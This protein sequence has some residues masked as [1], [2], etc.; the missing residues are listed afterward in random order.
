MK[1]ILILLILF[2]NAAL[3]QNFNWIT[4]NKQ[5][6]KLYISEDGLYRINKSDFINS[7][8][9]TSSIDPRTVK[10][11]Y[12]GA[13]IPIYFF[14]E[15]NGIFD[16]S[17]YFDFYGKRNYGGTTVTYKAS[18]SATNTVD[19]V[20][21]EY[22]NLYSDTS[23]YWVD[24]G[25]T[26]GLRYSDYVNSSPLNYPDTYFLN[27]IQFE[28]DSI[29]S[30]GE[31][32]SNDDYRNFN[33]EKISGEGWFW[34]DMQRGNNVSGYFNLPLLSQ[35]PQTCYIKLFAYP[36]S[37]SDTIFN[38]HK[39]IIRVN[40]T[41]IDTLFAD[42]YQR[43]DTTVNFSSALLS[44][45]S[46]NQ[47]SVTYTGSGT[48]A[49]HMLFDFFSLK[50]PARFEFRDNLLSFASALADTSAR[51]FKVKG[52]VQSGGINIYDIK[53][54][55]RIPSVSSN[56]DTLIFTGK[57]N[58]QYE[59]AN[60]T[61]TKKPF[62][63]KQ[64][65]VPDFISGSNGT[66]YLLIYNKLLE[67]PAEM[68]RQHRSSPSYDNF[69]TYKAEIEDIY[70][71][72]NYGMEN[73]VA[74]RYFVKYAY[75]NWQT[76]K[77]SYL[78]L[79]GRGSLDP[80]G[81]MASY[82]NP[83]YYQNLIPVYGNPPSDGYYAN[84]NL[85]ASTYFNQISV[86]RIPALTI[87]EGVDIVNKTIQYES[88]RTT[89]DNW[90]KNF[91]FITGGQNIYEQQNFANQ[92]DDLISR[93]IQP[94]PTAG[95]PVR[96]YRSDSSGYIS[97]NYS[98]SIKNAINRG[99]LITNY[100][101][102]AA[103]KSWDNGIE[104]P[105]ILQNSDKLSLI[106][107]MTCFT[108]KN[109]E[110]DRSFGET[111]ITLQN[112]GA[113]GFVGTTGWS[114][115]GSGNTFNDYMLKSFSLDTMRRT[116]DI[117]RYA[118]I[119]LAQDSASYASKNTVNCYSLLGDPAAMLLIPK[120]SEFAIDQSNY[121]L[122]NQFPSVREPVTLSIRPRN[123]GIYADSVK[124][125]FQI[126]KNSKPDR[127]KDT[128]IYG[129]GF[130]DTVDYL[131]SLDSAGNYNMTVT[132]DP[133]NWNTKE[134]KNNNSI[135]FQLN[136]KNNSFVP[137][138]PV[139]NQLSS[140]DSV[141]FTGINPNVDY[142]SN[143][144]KL[145]LQVDTSRQFG[146]A[147]TY[148][149]NSPKGVVTSFKIK[150][151]NADSGRVFFWR[152]NSVVNG[153]SSGWSETRKI[154]FGLNSYSYGKVFQDSNV[155]VRKHLDGQFTSSELSNASS[156]G[157]VIRLSNYAGTVQA[158]SGT[159]ASYLTSFIRINNLQYLF[160]GD[161]YRG[162]NI[163]KVNRKTANVVDYRNFKINSAQSSDSVIGYLNTFDTSDIAVMVKAYNTSDGVTMS[164]TARAKIREFGS[165]LVDSIASFNWY[166]TWSFI[167]YKGAVNSDV[168]ES[169]VRYPGGGV[170]P[171]P[172]LSS[173]DFTFIFTKGY[174]YNLAGPVKR[175]GNLYWLKDT[176]NNTSC[177]LNIYGNKPDGTGMLLYSGITGSS[178]NLDT[179]A[180]LN[181]PSLR[182]E[183]N[184]SVDSLYGYYSPSVSDFRFNY[185]PPA[186]II[187]DNN[188]FVKT[189]SVLQEGDTLT[190]SVR[191]YNCGFASAD[192]FINKWSATSPSGI[193]T[194]K[195]DTVYRSLKIDSFITVQERLPTAGLRN[196]N[197]RYD[198]VTFYF[199][200][201][202]INQNEFFLYNNV[203]A[204]KSVLTGDTLKPEMDIT[205]D[206]IRAV[207]GEYIS[208]KPR[209]VLKF[210][211][212][213][214]IFIKDTS[215]IRV[216]LDG[217]YI[218]YYL[219]GVK[220]PLIDLVFPAGKYL[221]ATLYFN[222]ALSVGE[223]RFDFASSDANG[224]YSDTVTHYMIVNPDLSIADLKN[225]P[226]PMKNETLFLINLSGSYPPSS[227]KI[228]IFTVAGRV[229]KT[230][231]A[232][233]GIGYNQVFW[234]GRD[235]DGDY[236]AN[237]VY[238]YKLIIEGNSR[239][240]TALQK[241]VILK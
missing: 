144:V 109:A 184:L 132:L 207:S 164:A 214:K 95:Y 11:L 39:L 31:H 185:I 79:F 77:L 226:N 15:Q 216:K 129:F 104:N 154:V 117:V 35:T 151:Q 193:R 73:P 149:I 49:G 13:Q 26:Y 137:L 174:V 203:A 213:S 179:L 192:G 87:Q 201:K 128:V 66:D 86:G 74:V 110:G 186:E 24:W 22:Y 135:S 61:V 16:D 72:F 155:T 89:P 169:Y 34:K 17:D 78:C 136:L 1:R 96:I 80:K 166:N 241:L 160:V 37:Y 180:A 172:A 239:K 57:G 189:D 2:S 225:Y 165:R 45:A 106:L 126:F 20:T 176:P 108:G 191:Y 182:I 14:G 140:E 208:A 118:S 158:Q 53:N 10:V 64:K 28:K 188:S 75:E 152:M 220:N 52:Y 133:N 237:G 224:N 121:R 113:I 142:S 219:N 5:Y 218:P 130:I 44:A 204:V 159:V 63:M 228:K 107:S 231:D 127:T 23:V 227:A 115:S 200:T 85:N 170:D 153:D 209:I 187:A 81:N 234:D 210:L 162:L 173:R 4:P 93:Y 177:F 222:P 58:G 150:L 143:S 221:Q 48:Y 42:N 19:Y 100:I 65:Q 18:N 25:G 217:E 198:T 99:A 147:L 233:L 240:E 30:L 47:I 157:N 54:G 38:E 120:Y 33:T 56:G 168:S 230:I 7:G 238:F 206:G 190:V 50:Y 145:L 101:G 146:S 111:F 102:H 122:S 211:D 36:N 6:L 163:Y 98:D 156:N 103:S 124:I 223:H 123:L 46:V 21:D 43:I 3:S 195:I 212:D 67:Q 55:V 171:I 235:A 232:V 94:P 59:I 202:L 51:V 119:T 199:E 134:L 97:Y 197:N 76:P 92:S 178:I 215:N 91:V 29:F 71:V 183:E 9:N 205:Y 12:K 105:G 62:R 69:R 139:D 70:D 181:F 60:M 114:F 125:R 32:R 148:F 88:H 175:Y 116:G 82:N 68:L 196:R 83:Y 167:G 40:G 131:F 41:V 229:I 27:K 84:F 90:F 138:K 194:L 161:Q 141:I 112:K 8:I 236:I